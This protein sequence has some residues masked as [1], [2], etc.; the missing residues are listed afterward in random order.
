M[1]E[2]DRYLLPLK[3]QCTMKIKLCG[4]LKSQVHM[5]DFLSHENNTGFSTSSHLKLFIFIKNSL[6]LLQVLK[7]SYPWIYKCTCTC[8]CK[9][10]TLLV[11]IID[12]NM[13][14]YM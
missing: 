4:S 6:L 2:T 10:L 9:I 5:R 1:R 11:V 13:K 3:I 7:Y 14:R 8:V 12:K